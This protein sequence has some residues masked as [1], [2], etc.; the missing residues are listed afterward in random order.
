[1]ELKSKLALAL[2]LE[3][4]LGFEFDIGSRV[5]NRDRVTVVLE[6]TLTLKLEWN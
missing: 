1:M 4:A 3:S 6:S 2:E 5:A